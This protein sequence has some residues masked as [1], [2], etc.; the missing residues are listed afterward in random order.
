MIIRENSLMLR[1]PLN[2]ELKEILEGM[3]YE[4]HPPLDQEYIVTSN[5]NT[6]TTIS[7]EEW[8]TKDPFCSWNVAGRLDIELNSDK[9]LELAKPIKFE[10]P[11]EKPQNPR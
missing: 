9:F 2:S 5:V 11:D 3:G 1:K 4:F 7:K 10:L 8:E 6:V